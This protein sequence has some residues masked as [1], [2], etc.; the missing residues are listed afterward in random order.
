MFW[1]VRI[2]Q[3]LVDVAAS[4]MTD[5]LR[6]LSKQSAVGAM[7]TDVSE[8]EAKWM[9]MLDVEVALSFDG[10]WDFTPRKVG[11][12]VN[13]GMNGVRFHFMFMFVV[14]MGGV[15]WYCLV[16]LRVEIT[17]NAGY[18]TKIL[19]LQ[20]TPWTLLPDTKPRAGLN[21]VPDARSVPAGAPPR[22]RAH[23]TSRGGGRRWWSVVV[24]QYATVDD[25][26]TR[27]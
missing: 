8:L 11:F 19:C 5:T 21:I 9:E 27:Q 13:S 7:F 16:S 2:F 14:W 20:T 23:R 6:R 22:D 3:A 25:E 15:W 1:V 10:L 12:V 26:V 18:R 4:A 17:A 24:R